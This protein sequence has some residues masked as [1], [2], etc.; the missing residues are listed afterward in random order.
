M[1]LNV[2]TPAG[3]QG[4]KWEQRAAQII[5]SNWPGCRY[6]KTPTESG[7]VIDAVLVNQN[8]MIKC[9][10]ETKSRDCTLDKLQKEYDNEWLITF[11]KLTS[12]QQIAAAMCVDYWGFLHL[13]PDDIVL[14]VLFWTP[15]E[16]I[17]NAWQ[18]DFHVKK[19][20]TSKGVNGGKE[21]R[22][23]AFVDM[24]GVKILK[25]KA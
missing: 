10:A 11:T 19:L 22:N 13:V 3:A 5:T 23:N 14:P 9:V 8:N 1:T 7:A 16:R 2:Q 20:V 6:C 24:T 21:E 12:G 17:K 18:I 4:L 15:H 25:V